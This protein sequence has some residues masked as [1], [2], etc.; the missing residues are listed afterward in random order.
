[1]RTSNKVSNDPRAFERLLSEQ[2]DRLYGTALYLTRNAADAED[3][4]QDTCLRAFASFGRFSPGTDFRAWILT[5]LRNTGLNH[6]KRARATGK[7]IDLAAIDFRLEDP[8]TRVTPG[9]ASY[10]RY[11]I[12]SALSRL[13]VDHRKAVILAYVEGMTYAEIS[14]AL[15]CPIGT[16][17]SRIYRARGR[18][19]QHLV[20]ECA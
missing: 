6:R 17:M 14:Q 3:L 18:L 10:N 1:M 15:D 12:H 8:T 19:R 20:G 7:R 11:E 5:I 9:R 4:V 16:V 2:Q 13:S